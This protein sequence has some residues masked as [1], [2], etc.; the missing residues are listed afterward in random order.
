MYSPTDAIQYE[1]WTLPAGVSATDFWSIVMNRMADPAK[2][3]ICM[4]HNRIMHEAAIYPEPD[5]FVPDRWLGPAADRGL[6]EKAF[7]P[8]GRGTRSCVGMK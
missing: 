8:F 4:S 1:Q 6:A 3:P 7:V 2:T 5:S